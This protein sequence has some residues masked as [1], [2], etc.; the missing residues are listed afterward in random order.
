MMKRVKTK[1][2]GTSSSRETILGSESR[3]D[4]VYNEVRGELFICKPSINEL[5]VLV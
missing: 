2:S 3:R 4:K 5:A 1:D